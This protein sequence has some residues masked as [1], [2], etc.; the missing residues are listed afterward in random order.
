MELNILKQTIKQTCGRPKQRSLQRRHT[1]GQ[2]SHEKITR[3]MQ[4]KTTMSYHFTQVRMVIIKKSINNTCWRRCGEKGTL[5][6]CWWECKL[7]ENLNPDESHLKYVLPPIYYTA[8]LLGRPSPRHQ[9]RSDQISRSV[10][11]DSL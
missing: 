9:I 4:I 2:E 11:S 5:L 1:D 3:E 6:D 10:V 8:C 7:K